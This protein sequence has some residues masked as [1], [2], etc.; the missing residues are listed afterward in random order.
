METGVKASDVLSAS[1]P[2][3][4]LLGLSELA[5]ARLPAQRELLRLLEAYFAG[6]HHFC[7]YTFIHEPTFMQLLGSNLIPNSLLLIISATS[8]RYMDPECR[9]S[10][11]WADESRRQV[12]K[13]V[14]S[15]PSMAILQTLLLLQRYEWHRGEHMSAWILAGLAI[16]LTHALQLNIEIT[17]DDPHRKVEMPVTVQE[18]RRRLMWSCF[19]MDSFYE[20]GRRP[21]SGLNPSSIDARLPCDEQSFRNSVETNME[22]LSTFYETREALSIQG[23]NPPA[24]RG[25]IPSF[26]VSI[27]VLRSQI[28]NYTIPYHP[29]NR[30]FT[31]THAPWNL[32]SP[33]YEHRRRLDDWSKLLP[34][35]LLF[36]ADALRH[37][38]PKM[39][40]FMALHC[41]FHGCYCD[42]YRI[43]SY[44]TISNPVLDSSGKP[45]TPPESFLEH[46]RRGRLEHA[47]AIANIISESMIYINTTPDPV[48]SICACLAIRV[49]TTQRRQS[50]AEAL[51]LPD[52]LISKTLAPVIEM[53]K[54]TAVRCEPIRK[55]F[56]AICKRA[57]TH[58]FQIDFPD[59]SVPPPHHPSPPPSPSLLTYGTFGTIQ[60]SLLKNASYVTVRLSQPGVPNEPIQYPPEMPSGSSTTMD[61]VTDAST[62]TDNIAHHMGLQK[63][64]MPGTNWSG[65][66]MLDP[67]AL[68]VA[69]GWSDGTLNYT[70]AL[71]CFDWADQSLSLDTDGFPMIP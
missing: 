60:Q 35:E 12:M 59:S 17:N 8:L 51:G 32:D 38:R 47:Y 68:Q 19:V 2:D 24:V 45:A 9:L 18:I 37:R 48:V 11:I 27:T 25:S 56:S 6:P 50:D 16:R 28:L 23:K 41:L 67:Q 26:L 36:D 65:G 10:D 42:L 14:F 22:D 62:P 39:I 58:G 64:P 29:R 21:V 70:G 53:L 49:L 20:A 1:A 71:S 55:L 57:E 69:S 13:Q 40:S 4:S 61:G 52:G 54:A 5:H 44:V 46:C 15:L 63:F 43:G 33:F 30:G 34:E 3:P 7:F 31:P 66:T